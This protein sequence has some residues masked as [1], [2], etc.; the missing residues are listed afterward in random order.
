M[1]QP[2]TGR[3]VDITEDEPMVPQEEIQEGDI[4]GESY[5]QDDESIVDSEYPENDIQMLANTLITANGEVIADVMAG[6]RDS[7]DKL[8]KIL[9]AKLGKS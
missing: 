7:L 6:I 4:S 8:N 5:G 9:Y 2:P 1:T 3:L